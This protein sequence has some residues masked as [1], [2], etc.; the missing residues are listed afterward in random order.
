MP[1][2]GCNAEW[3][4]LDSTPPLY[5]LKKIN[6][7]SESMLFSETMIAADTTNVDGTWVECIEEEDTI[8]P[9]QME[10]EWGEGKPA[11]L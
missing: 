5:Q 10:E 1:I 4:Q 7:G 6:D 9:R 2:G 8:G 11:K 3:S